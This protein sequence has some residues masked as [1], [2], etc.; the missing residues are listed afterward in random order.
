MVMKNTVAMLCL[1]GLTLLLAAAATSRADPSAEVS[2]TLEFSRISAGSAASGSA[3]YRAESELQIQGTVT[4]SQS[5]AR[6]EVINSVGRES[7]APELSG[8]RNSF[9]YP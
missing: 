9:L 7:L 8:V 2:A 4:V 3:I 5:S 1:A 6:Y